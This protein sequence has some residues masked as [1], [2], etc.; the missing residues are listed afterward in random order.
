M[1]TFLS[2]AFAA[3]A[4]VSVAVPPPVKEWPEV[5]N[6]LAHYLSQSDEVIECEIMNVSPKEE[7]LLDATGI[8]YHACNVLVSRSFMGKTEVHEKLSIFVPRWESSPAPV[9][10]FTVNWNRAGWA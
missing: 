6:T 1:K 10:W 8:A 2:L 5:D 4:C 9:S 7:T 3:V